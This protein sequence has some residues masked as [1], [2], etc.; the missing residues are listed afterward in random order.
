[1]ALAFMVQ[2]K[3]AVAQLVRIPLTTNLEY[4]MAQLAHLKTYGVSHSPA[5]HQLLTARSKLFNFDRQVE[6]ERFGKLP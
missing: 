1:M 6:N 2:V 3:E 4:L 5:P